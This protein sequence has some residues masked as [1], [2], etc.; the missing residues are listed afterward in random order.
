MP[1]IA[2]RGAASA[3]GF[4]EFAQSAAPVYIEDV[5]NTYLWDGNETQ[6]S[7]VNGI[8]LSTKGGMVWIKGRS[9]VNGH[10]LYDTQ[11]GVGKYLQ[12]NSTAAQSAVVSDL[13]NAFNT[14]G[15]SLG[16]NTGNNATNAIYAGWTFREQPK[17]FDVVT[18]TGD[19]A[20]TQTIN[21]NLGS[22][23]GC[24]II[25]KVSA[26]SSLGWSVYHRSLTAG[27]YLLLNT[28]GTQTADNF[29]NG[30]NAPTATTFTAQLSPVDGLNANGAT[31]VA[32]LFAHNAGGFGLA[33]T[34]NVITCGS[35]TGDGLDPGPTVTLGYEPQWL[36]IKKAT[37]T[38]N[39]WVLADNLRGS[40]SATPSVGILRANLTDQEAD[41]ISGSLRP[42]A[43]GFRILSNNARVNESGVTYIY[44]AVRRGL[45]K[46]P[47]SGSTVFNPVT[48]TGDNT[49]NRLVN[50][51]LFM[52]ALIARQRNTTADTAFSDRIR[53]NYMSFTNLTADEKSYADAL[54][55]QLVG[56]FQY[57]NSFSSMAGFFVGNSASTLLNQASTP[58][59]AYALRRA[60]GF[61]DV[62]CYT[63]TGVARNTPH[64]LGVAP[65]LILVKSRG[66]LANW[67]VYQTTA[68]NTNDKHLRLNLTDAV[69]QIAGFEYWGTP[70]T[71]V[72]NMT[73]TT[74]GLG[75]RAE[76]NAN[77]TLYVA[78]LFASC[79]GVSKVG[80][81][82]GTG[83]TQTISC[84]FAARFVMIK[85][86]DN[87]G[88]WLF[89]DTARGMTAG[90]DPRL[91]FDNTA[92]ETNANWVYT[93]A[94]GFQIVVSDI[95]VNAN[96]GTYI[97]LAIA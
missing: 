27:S 14:N 43:T 88:G 29:M 78:Y 91:A 54:D 15:F 44:V 42:E 96:G 67:M 50:T 68:T 79:P 2:T 72:P 35:Y 77:G 61:F 34:D 60:P 46:T 31:Y 39:D 45:M 32:Y 83:S 57:G 95:S 84:G 21:H 69:T 52:D 37:G 17:F 40:V 48:Y 47:T 94:S 22:V 74:F 6:R 10:F 16:A 1:L 76:G 70:S 97:Y 75:T 4:G 5:F 23:P 26:S 93:D 58:Q 82:S 51:S 11:R 9:Q 90:T 89:W 63:G 19:G 73:A 12:S 64:N 36:L 8:D 18:Y 87:S 56:G 53:T 59:L 3:Q 24:I 41:L 85:R 33:G 7:I 65:E 20:S 66:T 13:L 38:A 28:S 92:G 80:S 71:A 49:D 30:G 81:Y 86:T 62:V 55:Q 25:K